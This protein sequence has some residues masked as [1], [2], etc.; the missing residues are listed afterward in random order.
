MT[1]E[2]MLAEDYSDL[3]EALRRM[4]SER[5]ITP[6]A[7]FS[8]ASALAMM[9]YNGTDEAALTWA[10][11]GRETKEEQRIYGS[12]HRD[13]P[14]A[15]K[16]NGRRNEWRTDELL[17][18]TRRAMREGVA[19]SSFPF[20]LMPPHNAVW[21]YALNVLVQPAADDTVALFPFE[22]E[23]QPMDDERAGAYALLDVEIYDSEALT[24]VYRYSAAHYKEESMRN[25]AALVRKYAEWLL[26]G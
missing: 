21:N 2:G 25:F 14:F 8:L 23:V 4:G 12:L 22:V 1:I 3:R 16:A 6:T 9:E 10:Y 15:I 26:N 7:F 5:L 11:D 19:H 18:Q 20:T 24:I 13:I 17:R